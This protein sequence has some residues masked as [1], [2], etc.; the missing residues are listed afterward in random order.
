LERVK[1][2]GKM[3]SSLILPAEYDE[4]PLNKSLIDLENVQ[5]APAYMLLL[6]LRLEN[7][8]LELDEAHLVLIVKILVKFF[9][10]RNLTNT[11]PTRDLDRLFISVILK[12][13]TMNLTGI[14]LVDSVR[15][16]LVNVSVPI[17]EMEEALQGDLYLDN[18]TVTRFLLCSMEEST[19]T[20]EKLVD[21]W[22]RSSKDKYVWTI[23][24]IFPQG[25]NIPAHWIEM[26]A[27]GDKEKASR[28]RDKYV[29]QLGNLTIS[30]YNSELGVKSFEQKRDRLD[31]EG[32]EVG[33]RNGLDLNSDLA[34][35]D[36]WSIDD[37]EERTKKLTMK[38]I[39]LFAYK[40]ESVS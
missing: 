13:N 24:H 14:A 2:A 1:N 34:S 31:K 35:K 4:T 16:Q 17:K 19:M 8:G 37:I 39:K 11:P 9:V 5:G 29:H 25:E 10:R 38:I 26:I 33:F 30:G 18:A 36:S 12:I 6:F 32:R 3:Y 20:R 27:Q 22:V 28:Y 23:E 15:K 21:L 7:K 40:G